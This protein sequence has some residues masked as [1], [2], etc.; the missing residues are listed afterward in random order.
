MPVIWLERL[1]RYWDWK[2]TNSVSSSN[3]DSASVAD[4]DD[5]N[6]LPV[7][8]LN[9]ALEPPQNGSGSVVISVPQRRNL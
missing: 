8:E 5:Q 7:P 3:S 2:A 4:F 6:T 1:I 9:E